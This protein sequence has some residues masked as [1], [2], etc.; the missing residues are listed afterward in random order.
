[1]SELQTRYVAAQGI[2]ES[3]AQTALNFF[4]QRDEL[5]IETKGVQDWV[6]NADRDVETEIRQAL[7]QQFPDD[8]IIGEEHAS[9]VGSSPYTWVIDPIDGTS[10]FVNAVPGWCVVLA[11]VCDNETVI[12]V[13]VDPIAKECYRAIK[14]G[15]AMMND[16]ELHVS[17]AEGLTDG[18]VAVGHCARHDS[19]VTLQLLERLIKS[20]GIFYRIGSGALML[21]YVASGRLIGYVE[22]HMN[23][24]DCIAGLFIIEQAGGKVR[25]FDMQE[26]LAKGGEIV[27]A[28]PGVYDQVAQLAQPA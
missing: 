25:P 13:I 11:C 26:M 22:A 2:A 24:Y 14:G 28:A 16:K 12:G 27:T 23:S 5:V 18:S 8:G 6:S 21:S 3:A 7:M 20:G 9:I 1:M 4:N 15:S 10:S 17:N 19:Q